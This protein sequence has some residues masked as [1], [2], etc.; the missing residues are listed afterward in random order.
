MYTYILSIL[1]IL[2]APVMFAK[3]SLGYR[4]EVTCLEFSPHSM[5]VTPLDTFKAV[6]YLSRQQ[7]FKSVKYLCGESVGRRT[8]LVSSRISLVLLDETDITYF[9]KYSPYYHSYYWSWYERW[10]YSWPAQIF[11]R[12]ATEENACETFTFEDTPDYEGDLPVQG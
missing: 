6:S 12:T 11:V 3:D 1:F 10:S 5:E 8:F 2:N 9:L 7:A 4:C